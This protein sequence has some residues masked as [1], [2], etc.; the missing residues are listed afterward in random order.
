MSERPPQPPRQPKK[1]SPNDVVLGIAER[2]FGE[3]AE[4]MEKTIN[5]Y[6][7]SKEIKFTCKPGGWYI[8]LEKIEVNADPMFFIERGYSEPEAL[9]ATFHEAEHFRDMIQNPEVYKRVFDYFKTRT[10][11]HPSYPKALQRLYNCIDDV[12]VNKVVMTRWAAGSKVKSALYPKL[13]PSS[14]LRIAGM[15]P[16]EQPYHRQFMYALLRESML[17]D[18]TCEVSPEVR[19]EIGAFQARLGRV[20]TLDFLTA[21]NPRSQGAHV[22]A[23]ERYDFMRFA[24]EPIFERLYKLDLE[25]KRIQEEENGDEKG[26][27]DDGR[28]GDFSDDPFDDAIPDPMAPGDLFDQAQKINEKLS[29]KKDDA[30][31]KAL[32]VEKGD[33]LAYQKDYKKIEKYITKLSE[34]FDRVIDR[35]KSYR[36]KLRK[37]VKEGPM[38]DSRLAAVGYAE[39]KAGQEDPAIMLDYE[40]IEQI[41]NMPNGLEFTIVCDGSGSV[42][43]NPLRARLERQLA[44]LAMEAFAEFRN[45]IEKEKRKG[46]RIE[47]DIK[48]ETRI[49]SDDDKVVQPLSNKFDHVSRVRLHKALLGMPGGG[50]NEPATFDAIR[51]EQFNRQTCDRLAKG[52]LK[53][54]IIFLTDG[55]TDENAIKSKMRELYN[56]AGTTGSGSSNLVIAGIGFAD[57]KQAVGTY[58][59]N[60]YYAASFDEISDIFVKIVENVLED[61]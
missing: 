56:L 18:E 31:K 1:A 35:R 4:A 14:N 53:K 61:V 11:V 15:P 24:L 5:S 7:G 39:I 19:A 51:R 52:E 59:P 40:K 13:F 58:A 6:F 2:R 41:R 26:K 34:V 42:S 38:L 20:K 17:P 46:E 25:N 22:D 37:R 9:F 44:V 33:F 50:N 30:F 55:Q 60:G 43:Y 3:F 28:E 8:D 21:V 10:D 12:L 57:G 27:G 32:G 36:R 23:E 16:R 47:L 49:F 29:Q 54:I 45:R 48:T